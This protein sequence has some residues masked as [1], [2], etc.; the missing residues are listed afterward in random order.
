MSKNFKIIEYGAN[1]TIDLA[2]ETNPIFLRAL[3]ETD[4]SNWSSAG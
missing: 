4:S 1:I 2:L 3:K